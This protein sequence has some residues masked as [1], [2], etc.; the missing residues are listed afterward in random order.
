MTWAPWVLAVFPAG[1]KQGC[2]LGTQ[3]LVI[4]R[5]LPRELESARPG[6][7]S[8][9]GTA[10]LGLALVICMLGL[11]LPAR[12]G[13][14]LAEAMSPPKSRCVIRKHSSPANPS[15]PCL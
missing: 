7:Q 2:V 12:G 4:S 5:E 6:F 10:F 15:P 13:G 11:I 3:E 9:T 8:P 1:C 14:G